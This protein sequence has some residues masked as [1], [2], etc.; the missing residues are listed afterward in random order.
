M[1]SKI[2]QDILNNIKDNSKKKANHTIIKQ[3]KPIP[4]SLENFQQIKENNVNCKIAYAKGNSSLKLNAF[5]SHQ[6]ST[7]GEIKR[8]QHGNRYHGAAQ[9]RAF[10]HNKG[11]YEQGQIS[12]PCQ[13]EFQDNDSHYST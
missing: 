1:N 12:H 6:K 13:T 4:F 9:L 10:C 11:Q 5:F 3:Y 2:I 7:D 8:A